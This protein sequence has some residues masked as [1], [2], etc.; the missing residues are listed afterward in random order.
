L[1]IPDALVRFVQALVADEELRLWFESLADVSIR[2]RAAEFQ[3]TAARMRAGSDDYEELA[4]A[5]ALLAAPGVYEAVLK[6]M[7]E[8]L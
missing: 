3:A 6:A 5:T 8:L 2:E 7:R 4:H 1:E